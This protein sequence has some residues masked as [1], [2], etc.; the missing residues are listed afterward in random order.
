MVDV[1]YGE[2]GPSYAKKYTTSSSVNSRLHLHSIYQCNPENCKT[3]L[4]WAHNRHKTVAFEKPSVG[5]SDARSLNWE[6]TKI[7]VNQSAVNNVFST[8]SPEKNI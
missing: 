4:E 1:S 3:T 2:K 6:Q 5:R 8:Q 7:C